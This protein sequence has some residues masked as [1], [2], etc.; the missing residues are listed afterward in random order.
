MSLHAGQQKPERYF[1]GLSD[2]VAALR[3]AMRHGGSASSNNKAFKSHPLLKMQT[4]K[5][6]ATIK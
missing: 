6:D 2:L 1:I 5:Y 3:S 4:T